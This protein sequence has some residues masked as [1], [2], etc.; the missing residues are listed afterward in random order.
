MSCGPVH[1]GIGYPEPSHQGCI[2]TYTTL[3]AKA[4]GSSVYI[5][6]LQLS[7]FNH[8][9]ILRFHV[10]SIILVLTHADAF[11]IGTGRQASIIKINSMIEAPTTDYSGIWHRIYFCYVLDTIPNAS[12]LTPELSNT[13]GLKRL[14][15]NLSIIH[16]QL[17]CR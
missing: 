10:L 7:R 3:K 9:H 17:P 6:G 14:P 15:F 1:E 8:R 4:Q 12:V 2:L 13:S 16:L 11:G 5:V